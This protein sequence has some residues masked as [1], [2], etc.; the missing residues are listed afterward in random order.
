MLAN[1]DKELAKKYNEVD[2]LARVVLKIIKD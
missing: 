1:K 2:V